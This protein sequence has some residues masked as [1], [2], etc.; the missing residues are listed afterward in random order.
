MT[1]LRLSF[2]GQIKG[3]VKHR[4]AGGKKLVE[5]SVCK[6]NRTKEG[7]PDAFT[8]IRCTIW[9]P[10]DFQTPKLVKGAFIAGTGEMTARSFDGKDGKQFSI[11]VNCQSFDVEVSDGMPNEQGVAPVQR[12]APA[13]RV[14]AKAAPAAAD[15]DL[16]SPPF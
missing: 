12:A 7:E 11:E 5:V 10:A 1:I 9:S 8:W 4:E 3:E 15:D 14:P 16:S 13:P 6:K 2:A